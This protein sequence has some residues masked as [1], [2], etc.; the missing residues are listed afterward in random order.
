MA[1]LLRQVAGKPVDITAFMANATDETYASGLA[2][3]YNIGGGTVSYT[4]G[5][6][7]TYGLQVRYSF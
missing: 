6:P 5:E 3:F 1:L 7:R 4:Y 2:D